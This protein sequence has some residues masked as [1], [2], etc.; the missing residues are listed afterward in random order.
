[1]GAHAQIA[2]RRSRGRRS[3]AG[4]RSGEPRGASTLRKAPSRPKECASGTVQKVARTGRMRSKAG[5]RQPQGPTQMS[6][7]PP[8]PQCKSEYTYEDASLLIC[9]E[10]AHEWSAKPAA[11]TDD[12]DVK[13]YRDSAGNEL[14]DG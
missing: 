11:A 1:G 3:R 10:C 13:V 2:S 8:C 14:Q 6:T 12:D 7:L 5:N 4:A 9:P